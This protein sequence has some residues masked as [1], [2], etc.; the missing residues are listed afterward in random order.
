[1]MGD[2]E[3]LDVSK[4]DAREH[5]DCAGEAMPSVNIC[6]NAVNEEIQQHL[7]TVIN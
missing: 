6:G 5:A 1:M 2:D 4:S 7:G 3:R